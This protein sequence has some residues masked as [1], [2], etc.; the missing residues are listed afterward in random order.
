MKNLTSERTHDPDSQ[1]NNS[2]HHSKYGISQ[3]QTYHISYK[4]Y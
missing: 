3:A 4:V 1:S 2:N